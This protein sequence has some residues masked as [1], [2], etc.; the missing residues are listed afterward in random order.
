MKY[1]EEAKYIWK[2]LVPKNGQ[3]NNLQ[4]ELL[5]Q[6]EKLR[7]EAQNNGNIN[8]DSNFEYFCDF[9][10]DKL[11]NSEVLYTEEKF[12]VSNALSKIKTTGQ[13]AFRYNNGEIS[14]EEM[15]ERYNFELAYVDDDLYDIVVDAIAVFYINHKQPIPYKVNP[16]IYR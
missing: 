5:R 14:D 3:A 6:L 7:Y 11:C 13:I 2:N 10:N 1:F 9:L 8:W 12:S 16:N 4:G 15:E